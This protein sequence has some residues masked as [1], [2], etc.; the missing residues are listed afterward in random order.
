M[1]TSNA[2]RVSTLVARTITEFN[3]NINYIYSTANQDYVEM[4]DGKTYAT[5]GTINVKV[6]G[7]PAVERGLSV[8]PTAIQ[9]L[10]VPLTITEDDIY[11]VTREISIFDAQFSIVGYD[12]ALTEDVESRIVD[13]YAYPAFL[14]LSQ[15]LEKEIYY[16]LK[17]SS[18]YSPIDTLDALSG[19]NNFAA[20]Q[21]VDTLMGQLQLPAQDRSMIYN[22]QDA[23][24]VSASLQN[25]FNEGVNTK[26]TEQAWIGGSSDKG[27]LAGLDCYRSNVFVKHESGTLVGETDLTVVSVSSDGT[28]I[29]IQG[30]PS[31]TA[32][33]INAGDRISIP[34]ITWLQ[35][36]GKAVLG[37][38][39]VVAAYEDADG[40]G[41]GQVTITLA[42]PLLASGEHANV[43]ALPAPGAN[44]YVFPDY[45]FNVAYTKSGLSVVPLTMHDIYGAMNH[46]N[47]GQQ[48]CPVKVG[49]QGQVT[50]YQNVFRIAQMVGTKAFTPYLVA[51]PSLAA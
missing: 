39:V 21:T 33:L 45:N 12:G 41:S 6:P 50:E 24:N 16:K 36:V 19:V 29:V 28:E 30:A 26:V 10:V 34:S 22:F 25:M 46:D 38:K 2:F 27:R 51:L 18:W 17:I 4:F 9:D 31:S 47:K 48:G 43:S 5:G 32:Q 40:N 11:N 1:P 13:N 44:V 35:P 8:T 23:A 49:L 7:Y 14:S 20:V 3:N 42:M 37:T 15:E